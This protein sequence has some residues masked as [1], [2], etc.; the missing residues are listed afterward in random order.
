M[1][2]EAR[3]R[4]S[5]QNQYCEIIFS[6]LIFPFITISLIVARKEDNCGNF[7]TWCKGSLGFYTADLI[8]CMNQLMYVKKKR[9]DSYLYMLFGYI[10]LLGNTSWYI[11]GNVTYF[12]N[13][14]ECNPLPNPTST[15]LPTL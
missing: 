11:Y 14:T 5:E 10:I 3:Q 7:R 15:D 2:Q 6:G 1:A 12:Q 9:G 4:A 8:L 13:M